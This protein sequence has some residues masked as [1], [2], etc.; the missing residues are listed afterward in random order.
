MEDLLL[1]DDPYCILFVG[2]ESGNRMVEDVVGVILDTVYTHQRC[3]D[4]AH[5][6]H[7]LQFENRTFQLGRAL[8]DQLAKLDHVVIEVID[9]VQLDALGG[10][11]DEINHIV[12]GGDQAVD[13][14]AVEG[15]DEIPAQFEEDLMGD[16]VAPV[17]EL[18][19]LTEPAL[20]L[21]RFAGDKGINGRTTFLQ[22]G[23]G[24]VE[25]GEEFTVLG[26]EILKE[27]EGAHAWGFGRTNVKEL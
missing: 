10:T 3:R 9:L 2:E 1:H 8:L 25:Q 20:T 14:L 23:D 5:L 19:D 21:L 13:I 11:M 24:F 12:E 17:F 6:P 22:V 26:N 16:L 27:T 18:L 7:V 15:G 4:I